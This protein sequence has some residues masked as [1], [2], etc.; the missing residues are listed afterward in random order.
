MGSTT[1][2]LSKPITV[3]GNEVTELTVE[4][5]RVKHLK[6]MRDGA[7]QMQ[8]AIDMAA[9]CANVPA[10]SLDELSLSDFEAVSKAMGLTGPL[11]G[12]S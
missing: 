2:K 6:T 8:T 11:A 3:L 5:A 9:A 10:S 1:V 12:G 4:Q 7:T